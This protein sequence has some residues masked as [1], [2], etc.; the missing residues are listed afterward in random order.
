M[1][2]PPPPAASNSL[3]G[4]PGE[5]GSYGPFPL[6]EFP[7]SG[8]RAQ[9]TRPRFFSI[10]RIRRDP[11]AR[12][13][14]NE[15]SLVGGPVAHLNIGYKRRPPM[16]FL[17]GVPP[18]SPLLAKGGKVSSAARLVSS[19]LRIDSYQVFAS[20]AANPNHAFGANAREF[21][22][23]CYLTERIHFL[24]EVHAWSNQKAQL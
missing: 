13:H 11:P 8:F 22:Q 15:P 16:V 1:I 12:N 3:A 24:A 2:P 5:T 19:A 14:P 6:I 21:L 4:P 23:D 17:S 9:A 10:R 18:F 7:A 20:V